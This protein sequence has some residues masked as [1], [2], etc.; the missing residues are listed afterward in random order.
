MD[1][2]LLAFESLWIKPKNL[3]M[4]NLVQEKESKEYGACHFEIDDKKVLFRSAKIT[5]TKTGQFV[6][7]WKRIGNGPILPFDQE[8][9]IDLFIVSVRTPNHFGAFIFP[10]SI[11]CEKGIISHGGKEGKRAM[12]VYPSWDVAENAQAK[13]TQKWQLLYFFKF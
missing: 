2:D 12:R 10:K 8:D 4:H 11:L 13:K 7:L 1:P 9:P 5:P 3:T 6:T